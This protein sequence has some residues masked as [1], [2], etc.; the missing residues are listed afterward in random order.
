[1]KAER[2]SYNHRSHAGNA[3]DVWKHF[4][5]AEVADHLLAGRK[6]ILY[7]ES[8]VGYPEYS[9]QNP[10][11]WERGIGRCWPCLSAL[12]TFCYFRIVG[13]MNPRG[14]VSYPGSASL[15]LE[16]AGRHGANVSAEIWDIDPRVASAWHGDSR[17]NFELGDGFAGVR[18]LLDRS[19]PGLL[20]ID[21]PYLDE[22]DAVQAVD[23][24]RVAEKADWIVLWWQMMGAET[25]HQGNFRSYPLRFSDAGLDGDRWQGA[26]VA[27]AGA[28]EYLA[29]RLEGSIQRFLEIMRSK[30][31]F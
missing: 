24:L 8:H 18:P 5:L 20:L 12:K 7:A 13:D 16:T 15:V 17:V 21:P 25:L 4:L 23:L 27:V 2:P 9:L 3:G 11:E 29:E 31:R 1:M 30:Q 14:L 28:D 22:K 26:I 19:P 6:T 10:G